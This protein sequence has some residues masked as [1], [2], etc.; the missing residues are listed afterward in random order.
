MNS[1][2]S[3]GKNWK[4]ILFD[5][6]GVLVD[7][8]KF[9][10]RSWKELLETFNIVVSD[11]FIYEHEGA[12]DQEIIKNLFTTCGQT[13]TDGQIEEVYEKQNRLFEENYIARV[14]FFP[15]T[16]SLLEKLTRAGIIL[17]LVTSSR[18]NLVT[19]IWGEKALGVFKS[20][21][22]ADKTRRFKP[23]P[24]PY[25]QALEETGQ[26]SFD[27]LVIENAPAG[28]QSALS[29]GLTCFAI[30]STLPEEKL[31]QAHR[32]FSDLES[33]TRFLDNTFQVNK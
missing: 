22:S 20:I 28:I 23:F 11:E 13:I 21:V 8:M 9:H 16:C 27:T 4:T 25:L 14:E 17:G 3:R 30:A 5:M 7:S 10:M 33:L 15:G 2:I 18:M 6:D 31:S 24:D 19:K 32:I 12:M 26:N 29:A 1:K